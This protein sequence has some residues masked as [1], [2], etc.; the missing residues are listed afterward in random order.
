MVDALRALGT[1]I[2]DDGTDWRLT[3]SEIAAGATVDCGL[4]GTVM[5]FVP[6]IATLAAHGTTTFDGDPRARERPMRPL[7]E[8]L[9]G[10][11]ASIDDGGRGGLPFTVRGGCAVG[12]A[13]TVDASASSQIVSGLL[14]TAPRWAKGVEVRHSGP[15]L[16]SLPHI[17]MTV[18]EL[19]ACGA[20]VETSGRNAWRVHPG[21]LA[22]RDVTIEP[23]LSNAA[24]FAAAAVVTGGTVTIVGWPATTTQPGAALVD[25]LTAMGATATRSEGGLTVRGTGTIR[26]ID[27]DLSETSEL[28]PVVAALAAL[29]DSPSR[30]RGVA[31][32]RGHETD[33]IAALAREINNLGGDVRETSDGLIIHPRP[34]SSGMFRTYDDHR[35]AT[36]AALIGLIVAGIEIENVGTT[37]KTM[38]DFPGQ[39][40]AMLTHGSSS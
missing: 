36:A 16:P 6:P 11:G 14:L 2:E 23:D 24:P 12:G 3:P 25:L 33:R 17:V 29:A 35:L 1:T 7:I 22:G 8:A 31:H 4:A 28:F 13:I 9:R 5:R 38:P 19:R 15:P 27:A 40:I 18:A 39:W 37:A 10:L 34:L 30:L 32:S 21:R 20:D 26:G